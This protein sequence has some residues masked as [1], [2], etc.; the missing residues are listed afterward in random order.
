MIHDDEFIINLCHDRMIS[1]LVGQVCLS[2]HHMFRCPG[3]ISEIQ[4]C[5]CRKQI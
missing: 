2:L 5:L 3:L 4:I 1:K